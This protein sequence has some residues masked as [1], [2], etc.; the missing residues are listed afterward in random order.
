VDANQLRLKSKKLSSGRYQVQ[1][2]FGLPE[3]YYGYVL[4]EPSTPLREVMLKIERHLQAAGEPERYLQRNLFSVLKR[5]PAS[6]TIVVFK[7]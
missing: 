2:S 5:A 4:A 1:F 7:R 6:G 3:S